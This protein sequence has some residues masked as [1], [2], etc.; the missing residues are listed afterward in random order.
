L[1]IDFAPSPLPH[2]GLAAKI[3]VVEAFDKTRYI[4]S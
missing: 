4:G 3:G 1:T 2:Q